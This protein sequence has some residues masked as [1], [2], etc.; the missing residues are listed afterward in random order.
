MDRTP[1]IVRCFDQ[2]N[3]I[4]WDR[5]W[6]KGILAIS[7]FAV[8]FLL[9]VKLESPLLQVAGFLFVAGGIVVPQIVRIHRGYARQICPSCGKEAGSYNTLKNRI[10]LVCK[11]C[12]SRTPTDC[13]VYYTGGP[14]SRVA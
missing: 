1:T 11:H 12:D 14:P 4:W 8:F 5:M 3:R 2:M 10:I 13:A 9:G 7:I 6:I